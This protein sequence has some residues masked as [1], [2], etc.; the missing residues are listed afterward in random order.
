M[1]SRSGPCNDVQRKSKIWRLGEGLLEPLLAEKRK[2]RKGERER[3]R[4]VREE[5]P[6]RRELCCFCD[7]DLTE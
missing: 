1:S 3:E 5:R 2:S 6:L 4:W 7:L